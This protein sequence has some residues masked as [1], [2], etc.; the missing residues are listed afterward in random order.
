MKS[1]SFDGKIHIGMRFYLNH[2]KCEIAFFDANIVRYAACDGG[3]PKMLPRSTFYTLVEDTT[4]L[5]LSVDGSSLAEIEPGLA[6]LGPQQMAGMRRR[7]RYV[8]GALKGS[9]KPTSMSNLMA[10]IKSVHSAELEESTD[11]E[12]RDKLRPP[13]PSTV[14]RWIKRFVASE[15]NV[16]VLIPLTHQ[17]GPQSKRLSL[18]V[19][20]VIIDKITNDYLAD[21]R[22]TGVQ[23]YCNVVGAIQE[24]KAMFP[25]GVPWNPSKRTIQR[26]IS[27]VDPY[28][29]TLYRYGRARADRQARP[30][31]IAFSMDRPMQLVFMDGHRMDVIVIDGETGEWLGRPF[32]VAILDVCTRAL[33]GWFISLVPFCAST[34]IAAVKD[35]CCRNAAREP[36]GVPEQITPD[37]GPDLVAAAL[38]NFL[39]KLGIHFDPTKRLDPNGKAMLERFFGTLNLQ[40][41]HIFPGTTFSSPDDRGDYKSEKKAGLTLEEIRDAF[42]KWVNTVYHVGVHG[43]TQRI[44]SLDWRDRQMSYPILSYSKGDLDVMARVAHSKK[45][46]NGRVT[47][48]YL[49]WKSAALSTFEQQGLRDVIVLVDEMNLKYAYVHP[50][51]KPEMI[52]QADPVKPSYMDGLTRYEHENV[53][54]KMKEQ[55]QKDLREVGEFAWEIARYRLYEEIHGRYA[56]FAKRKLKALLHE[57]TPP[58]QGDPHN[59]ERSETKC[60]QSDVDSSLE[61]TSAAENVA[62]APS[63]FQSYEF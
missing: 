17:R 12:T 51:G 33:V 30:A 39:Q 49:H 13:G 53:K 3:H 28:V 31:G 8:M 19:E 14:A 1:E 57:S 22:V 45:I 43:E 4:I 35:M 6:R 7:L 41:S 11:R 46:S 20:S 23:T 50:V 36:G 26:R 58:Q 42:A 61:N 9:T 56:K 48:N 24:N 27:E 5:L 32:L 29:R 25:D 44:P 38:T 16:V 59:V 54:R 2:V 15:F 34:A 18:P 47:H 63:P 21:E 60:E 10:V 52:V 62:N 37:L 40:L 55:T